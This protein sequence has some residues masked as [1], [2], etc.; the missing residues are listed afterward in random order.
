MP[1]ILHPLAKPSRNPALLRGF[2]LL[3]LVL[4]AGCA[5]GPPKRIFPPNASVQELRRG[6]AGDWTLELR[7][8]NFSTVSMRFDRLAADFEIEGQ[9]AAR[10]E[11]PIGLEVPPNTAEVLTLPLRPSASASQ[12]LERALQTRRGLGYRLHGRLSSSEPNRRDDA[13]D[14]SSA[15]TP[16]PGLDGVLR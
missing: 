2:G 10:I 7:L 16:M 5:S 15:L 12:A 9:L 8:Q 13:F 11:T 1:Q 4:L 6:A 3:L 14:H